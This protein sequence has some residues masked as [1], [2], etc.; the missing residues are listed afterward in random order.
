MCVYGGNA[1]METQSASKEGRVSLT[2]THSCTT[3]FMLSSLKVWPVGLPGLIT[4]SPRTED[5]A[6]RAAF[7]WVLSSEATFRPQPEA[8]SR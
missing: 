7:S 3:S 1:L 6:A 4:T 2:S 8:S 5:P